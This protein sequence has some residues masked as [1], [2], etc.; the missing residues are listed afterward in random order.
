MVTIKNGGIC[1]IVTQE[2]FESKYRD[3]GFSILE[4]ETNDNP[5]NKWTVK[6][7]E[8]YAEKNQIELGEAKTKAEILEVIER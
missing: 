4:K 7:L 6:Q 2:V 3:K 8:A 5:T 1:R